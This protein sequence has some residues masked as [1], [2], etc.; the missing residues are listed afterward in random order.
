M[1]VFVFVFISSILLSSSASLVDPN[2]V[3]ENQLAG[4]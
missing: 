4:I 2:K 1:E 3:S